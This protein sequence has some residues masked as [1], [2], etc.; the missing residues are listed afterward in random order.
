[1]F[2]LLQKFVPQL[3]IHTLEMSGLVDQKS[4]VYRYYNAAGK[5]SPLSFH[6]FRFEDS[7]S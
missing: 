5:I 1:M 6:L 3:L 2:P 4:K 7:F